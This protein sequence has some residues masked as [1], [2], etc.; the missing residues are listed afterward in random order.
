MEKPDPRPDHWG[1][2]VALAAPPGAGGASLVTSLQTAGLRGLVTDPRG[3][4]PSHVASLAD[5]ILTAGQSTWWAPPERRSTWMAQP[6][7]VAL[8]QQQRSAV[9][10]AAGQIIGPDPGQGAVWC[11]ERHPLLLDLWL[12]GDPPISGVVLLWRSPEEAVHQLR[13]DGIRHQHAVALWEDA[14][15]RTLASAVGQRVFV[16][17]RDTLT[18]GGEELTSAILSFLDSCGVVHSVT[19]ASLTSALAL[20]PSPPRTASDTN[21]ARPELVE[22]LESLHGAHQAFAP[23]GELPLSSDSDELLSAHRA[24]LRLTA[25]NRAA[26]LRADRA[27]RDAAGA[28]SQLAQSMTGIDVLVTHVLNA[29]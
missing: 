5:Q 17:N 1:S 22:L 20:H 2:V 11:D 19:A 14:V 28:L 6:D 25:E 7:V 10:K 3:L 15:Q 26:W 13:G 4:G 27:D 9:A 8:A 18:E 24:V 21:T 29:M 12:E 23:V 16:C